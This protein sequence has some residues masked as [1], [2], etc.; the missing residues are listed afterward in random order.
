MLRSRFVRLSQKGDTIVEVL[1]AIAVA[2]AVLGSAFLVVNKTSKNVR[3]SQEHAEALKLVEGQVELLRY[4]A[5]ERAL[6]TTDGCVDPSDPLAVSPNGFIEVADAAD[7]AAICKRN[8]GVYTYDLKI[9][10]ITSA[11][12]PFTDGGDYVISAEWF[13]ATGGATKDKV[14][15]AY[16]IYER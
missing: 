9:R 15:I 12:A 2:S 14:E 6:P 13:G 7:Y 11:P 4:R 3:Q 16:R 1:I 8:T 5:G 10:R